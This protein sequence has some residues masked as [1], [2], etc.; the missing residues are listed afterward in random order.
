MRY[1]LFFLLWL[2]A[3]VAG[4]Q[5]YIL[6]EQ[7][8][9]APA[10]PAGM[11]FG[12]VP[13]GAVSGTGNFGRNAPAINFNSTGQFLTYGPWTGAAD[14]ISFFYMG[15][16]GAASF[17]VVQ[18]SADGTNWLGVGTATSI[19]TGAT[20]SAPLLATS[21][22]VRLAF[23]KNSTCNVYVDDLRIR[24]A[25]ASCAGG[26]QLLQ[27]LVNGGCGSC[28]GAEEFVYFATGNNDLDIG[29]LELV[30]Q[31]VPNGG[32]AY[33][34][35]GPT[36]NLNTNWVR[37]ADFSVAQLNYIANLNLWASCSGVFVPVPSSNVIPA[38]ARVLAFTA[39]TPTATYNFDQLCGLGTVY[40]IFADQTD[41]GGKYTNAACSANC[42]RYLTLFNHLT[43]C[44][45]NQQYFA[46]PVATGAGDTYVFVGSSIGYA[47]TSECSFLV[48]PVVIESI[49]TEPAASFMGIHWTTSSEFAVKQFVVERS[50]DNQFFEGIGEVNAT[51]LISGSDYSFRDEHPFLGLNYYR[52]R[53]ENENGTA[54][55]SPVI[56]AHYNTHRPLLA[57]VIENEL[58]IAGLPFN[59]QIG[60][61]IYTM[62]GRLLL[63]R[64]EDSG[65]DGMM[66][67]VLLKPMNTAVVAVI[68]DA[69]EVHV[70]PL[71]PSSD[72]ILF[73]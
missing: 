56:S 2:F 69:E 21:R 14:Q 31:T 57:R 30:N 15:S 13:F 46:S 45:D 9:A 26:L 4:G 12:A 61:S 71:L 62:D 36:D 17:F 29:Y 28:E 67:C 41:C 42:T 43:G 27:V 54:D 6:D 40:V 32:C 52:L 50:T 23:N 3:G 19:T 35:N 37:H 38:G 33:G 44:V 7:F 60:L 53:I 24:S 70:M 11:A 20:Y 10:P 8:N 58:V 51:N 1:V 64:S 25:S 34:G 39:A 47:L 16:T 5:T 59:R 72:W 18:Q 22:Y 73:R 49:Y 65:E 48:L 55:Y 63:E 66:R 68:R